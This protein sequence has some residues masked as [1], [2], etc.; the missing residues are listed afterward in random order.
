VGFEFIVSSPTTYRCCDKCQKSKSTPLHS[1]ITVI[2]GSNSDSTDQVTSTVPSAMLRTS[3]QMWHSLF[4]D[5][6]PVTPSCLT[7]ECLWC[8]IWRQSLPTTGSFSTASESYQPLA[9]LQVE[10]YYLHIRLGS[11][12]LIYKS[13]T[14]HLGVSCIY[15][16]IPPPELDV[17]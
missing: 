2:S 9:G 11:C 10:F 4:T 3:P 7:F 6:P 17:T 1:N 12:L 14:L 16:I 15:L 13:Q 5:R 8:W